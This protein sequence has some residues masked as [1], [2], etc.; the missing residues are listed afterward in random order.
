MDIA[1]VVIASAARHKLLDEFVIPSVLSQGFS[2][3]VVVGPYHSGEGY[4]HLP[5][6]PVTNSPVDALFKRDTG[7]VATR[8]SW[9]F[10]LSDDHCISPDFKA[11]LRRLVTHDGFDHRHILVPD[12]YTRRDETCIPLNMGLPDKY[13][14]GHGGVFHRTAI[15]EVPWGCVPH[16]PN[17]DVIHS[18]MLTQRGYV[19]SRSPD[20][21][22]EDVE[23]NSTP[24]K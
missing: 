18:D 22:I 17:W 19:L 13:C 2:E 24:W 9:L 7:T 23:P 4:R 6:D 3:V 5:F 21:R 12:R 11:G 10:Y 16:H 20:C 1:C 15:Q 8:S 14:A